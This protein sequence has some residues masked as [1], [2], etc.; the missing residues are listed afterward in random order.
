MLPCRWYLAVLA[1]V[2]G[3][4]GTEPEPEE[5]TIRGSYDIAYEPDRLVGM[6]GNCDRLL[7]YAALS[8]NEVYDFNLLMNTVDD[9]SRIQGGIT[10]GQVLIMGK[11]TLEGTQFSFTPDEATAPLFLGALDG[12]FVDLSLPPAVGLTTTHVDLRV[13]PFEPY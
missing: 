2:L 11:Y 10:F 3:S 13:G 1:L 4:C 7:D 6:V 12:E 8:M 9:C 5:Q